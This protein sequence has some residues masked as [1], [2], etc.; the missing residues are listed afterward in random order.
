[1]S[2]WKEVWL[3]PQTQQRDPDINLK[4]KQIL[5]VHNRPIQPQYR[6]ISAVLQNWIYKALLGKVSPEKALAGAQY[7]S[8]KVTGSK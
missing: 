5:G 1:M 4:G 8:D 3:D 2:V 7:E 6:R